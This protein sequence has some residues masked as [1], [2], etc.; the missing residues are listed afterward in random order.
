MTN[1]IISPEAIASMKAL[2]S[3]LTV[4]K[5][6]WIYFPHWIR[7]TGPD[8]VSLVSFEHLPEE[9]KTAIGVGRW[10][11]ASDELKNK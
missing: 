11:E 3:T 6:E 1:Y 8:T 9:V 4:G 5:D 7:Q 2:G 10:G